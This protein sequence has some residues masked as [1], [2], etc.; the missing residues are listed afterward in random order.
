MK[1]FQTIKKIVFVSFL[2][3]FTI[4]ASA[5]SSLQE[6]MY[7][8]D[9]SS[10]KVDMLSDNDIAK[11]KA[12]L[13]NS[14]MSETQAEQLALQRGMS[15]YEI[16]K[17][18]ARVANLSS[19]LNTKNSQGKN[20]SSSTR[21]IDTSYQN[22][23]KS[24]IA[25]LDEE[26]FGSELF[27]NSNLDFSPDLRMATPK[28]Y[29]IGPDDEIAID[30][31]GYQETNPRL[32]VSPEGNINIP[33]VGYVAVNGISIE[34]AT[35]R[36]REKMIKNGYASIASGQTKL[37][38]SI[39]K[40][41]TIKVT[42]VGMARKPG[43]YTLSSLSSVFNALYACGGP[44][45]KGS[46]R[47]IEV[48]RGKKVIEKLDAYDFLLKGYQS[49]DI[50]LSDQ[51]V[52]RI[53]AANTQIKLRGEVKRPGIFEMKS[54]ES[55]KDLIEFAQGFNSKAYT[56]SV[57]VI[58]YTDK[59]KK[60]VDVFKNDYSV[61][62][63]QSGDEITVSRI[64]DRFSNRV[65][66]S[67]AVFRPGEYEL[68][69]NL[70]L[71]GLIQKA[72]GLKEDVY[73]ER[74]L[75]IRTNEDQSK[76]VIPF[77]LTKLL[78]G[79]QD[80]IALQKDD[81]IK[82]ASIKDFTLQSTVTIE[83]EV[84]KPGV[85]EFYQGLTLNDI[86]FQ[87]GGFT[88]AASPTRIEI[89]RRVKGD[90]ANSKIIAQVIEASSAFNLSSN[91]K[92]TLIQPWDIIV[93]RT[94]PAYKTQIT[95]RVEG[96]V[97]YPGLYTLNTKEDKISDIIKRAGGLTAQADSKGANIVRVNTSY[98]KDDA[99]SKIQKLKKTNDTTTNQIVE[100]ITKPTVKV[101]LNLEEI[102]ANRG[103]I[104]ENITL[105]EGDVIN[106]PKQRN[107][108]KVNGEVM[109][110][111]EIVYKEGAGLD[112][113]INKAGGYTENARIKKIYVLNANGSASKTKTF[114]G[115]K[116][117]PKITAGSEIL[118]PS[119]PEKDKKGLSTAEWLAI[120]SGMASLA[121]VAVAIINVTK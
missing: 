110:P 59:D 51:D 113:Y 97:L 73:K 79:L 57:H 90:S 88:D 47:N 108:V 26:Y 68:T 81:S 94:N 32:I 120:A 43:T 63:P 38:V 31:Y 64:L 13:Q 3:S 19:T 56:A 2:L 53:P 42:I 117:Y 5:Q 115:F 6:L 52:I 100:D 11:Y 91:E 44:N 70:S 89:A 10:F 87:T 74:G 55:M 104:L 39:S 85:Y 116:K 30:V 69:Q 72:D 62:K 82:V 37:E 121:G 114:L 9:L 7:S 71:K 17:L 40:I 23:N 58:Q 50:R 80:D 101:A 107:V 95:V 1:T 78:S 112:Y 65:V 21:G 109:L 41:R 54:G 20:A 48:I 119:M 14:G 22:N 86:L 33:N 103:N 8:K 111:T 83:G 18:K 66:I 93:V 99:Q 76:R 102:L 35:K 45:D 28:N 105:I 84:K 34:A 27:N 96:E 16:T 15:S 98:F 77:N 36:I 75:L 25:K 106:I 60:V 118:V 61:Y 49:N 4:F 29:I 92:E 12:Y 46:F 24:N 67:G